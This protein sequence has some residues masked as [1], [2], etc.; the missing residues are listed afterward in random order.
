MLPFSVTPK[1]RHVHWEPHSSSE[2]LCHCWWS[3]TS[4]Q[5]CWALPP[6]KKHQCMCMLPWRETGAWERQVSTEFSHFKHSEMALGV[7][8]HPFSLFRL[9]PGLL[10]SSYPDTLQGWLLM[11]WWGI[12]SILTK[13]QKQWVSQ[14]S[15]H[16]EILNIFRQREGKKKWTGWSNKLCSLSKFESTWHFS[17]SAKDRA[18]IINCH[19]P[20]T[21]FTE[22]GNQSTMVFS[23]LKRQFH[24]IFYKLSV[25]K[26][27]NKGRKSQE[28]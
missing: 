20:A 28:L 17:C 11:K 14:L 22:F 18:C 6:L 13:I 21:A 2:K 9:A 10:A 24:A 16:E 15:A 27:S 12:R 3:S 8:R 7:L 25:S 23:M 1:A 19:L 4:L 26:L 5:F